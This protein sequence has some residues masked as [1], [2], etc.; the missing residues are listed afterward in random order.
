MNEKRRVIGFRYKEDRK[1][2]ILVATKAS[3]NSANVSNVALDCENVGHNISDLSFG[4]W[5]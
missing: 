2:Y 1:R 5:Q 3:K 4:S